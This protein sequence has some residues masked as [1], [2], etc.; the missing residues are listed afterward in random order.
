MICTGNPLILCFGVSECVENL[1][2]DNTVECVYWIREES[3]DRRDFRGFS[4]KTRVVG[5]LSEVGVRKKKKQVAFRNP[6]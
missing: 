4:R 2:G 1:G 3:R 5:N 6:H